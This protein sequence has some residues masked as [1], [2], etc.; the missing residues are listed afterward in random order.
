MHE[1]IEERYYYVREQFHAK[2]INLVYVP[3]HE[4][5]ADIFSKALYPEESLIIFT[6]NSASS[7]TWIMTTFKFRGFVTLNVCPIK[8]LV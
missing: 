1:H 3:T 2:E 5:V 7:N 6:R 8:D 4:N